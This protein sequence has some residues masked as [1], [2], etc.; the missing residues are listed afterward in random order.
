MIPAM[1]CAPFRWRP[2]LLPAWPHPVAKGLAVGLVAIG[3]ND[4]I[5]DVT[6]RTRPD[7]SGDDSLPSKHTSASAVASAMAAR[8]VE[9]LNLSAW[10]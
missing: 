3:V 10:G 4:G 8:N 9:Y 1:I 7:D 2:G 6:D 5:K